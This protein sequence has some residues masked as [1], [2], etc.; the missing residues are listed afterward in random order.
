MLKSS[1]GTVSGIKASTR[2]G[3]RSVMVARDHCFGHFAVR[4]V[5]G[6]QHEPKRRLPMG[7]ICDTRS[8]PRSP[9]TIMHLQGRLRAVMGLLDRLRVQIRRPLLEAVQDEPS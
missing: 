1:S 5:S 4:Y 8:S 2:Y 3:G 7:S 9:K 6:H